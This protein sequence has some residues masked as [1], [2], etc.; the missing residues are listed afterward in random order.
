VSS[1]RLTLAIT[2]L[3]APAAPA[4][5]FT[6]DGGLSH[7]NFTVGNLWSIPNN[8]VGGAAPVSGAATNIVFTQSGMWTTADQNIANPFVLNFLS[9]DGANN[10]TALTDGP[11][12]F[13][14]SNGTTPAIAQ[15]TANAITIGN[16]I[17]LTSSGLFIAGVAGGRL[18]LSG[19]VTGPGPLLSEGSGTTVLTGNNSY[20]GDT[21]LELGITQAGTS[22]ALSTGPLNFTGGTLQYGPGNNT[23]YSPRFGANQPYIIDTN[24][25]TVTFG[26]ALQGSSGLLKKLGAGTLT[27]SNTANNYAG[28]TFLDNGI[29]AVAN[30]SVLGA[31]SGGVTFAGGT[32]EATASFSSARGLAFNGAGGG[33]SVDSGMTLTLTGALTGPGLLAKVGFGTLILNG[34]PAIGGGYQVVR[35]TLDFVAATVSVGFG[36]LTADAGATIQYD[37]GTSMVGGFLHGPGTHVVTGGA[38]LNGSTTYNST[39]VNVIGAGSF[40]NFTNGGSFNV[41]TGASTSVTLSQITNG[42]SGSITIGAVSAVTAADFQSYGTLTL[43][44]AVVGSGQVTL[45]TNNGASPMYFNGGSRTFIG[46]PATASANVAG[47]DLHGQN[48]VVAG[49]LFVNNGFVGDSSNNGAGTATIVADFGSLVKGAGFFQNSVITQNGGKF[50]AGNSP[51]LASFGN[52]VMGPGGVSDYVFAINDASGTAGPSLDADGHVSGWGLVKAVKQTAGPLT[53]PGDFTWTATPTDKLTFAIDTLVNPTTVGTDI[54]GPMADF[55][56]TRTYRWPA[57][58]WTG[59]FAGPADVAA[60]ETATTFDTSGVDNPIV[61]SF[62]W[63]LDAS[64]RTLSLTY[65]PTPVPEPGTLALLGGAAGVSA[66]IRRRGRKPS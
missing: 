14:F 23:D 20:T 40:I 44:P 29:L 21:V 13:D 45:L 11:L 6:W 27:L 59:S 34:S 56:P 28:G 65:V 43:T 24:S 42:G 49:G 36:T 5:T 50:Q 8:W 37:A 48:A 22:G 57:V 51:G 61:G 54:A 58:Q 12:Q 32:L 35:G 55:D 26:S 62:G 38:V 63:S 60:L 31:A 46:T 19:N 30:D 3:F 53:S 2:L 25:Q 33:I 64:D 18:T 15:N 52:L 17:V 39:V 1:P 66:A 47:I 7:G 4:Q 16:A 10:F 9:F 41:T